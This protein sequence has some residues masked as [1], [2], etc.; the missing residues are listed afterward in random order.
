MK[1]TIFIDESDQWWTRRFCCAYPELWSACM[2]HDQDLPIRHVP[3]FI[4]RITYVSHSHGCCAWRGFNT[5]VLFGSIWT[6]ILWTKKVC[7]QFIMYLIAIIFNSLTSSLLSVFS[8]KEVDP[9]L[10]NVHCKITTGWFV[11]G[12]LENFIPIFPD[13]YYKMGIFIVYNLVCRK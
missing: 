2:P 4:S 13:Y 12:V 9:D 5:A 10:P 1:S 8:S 7:H 3:T 11:K 6:C